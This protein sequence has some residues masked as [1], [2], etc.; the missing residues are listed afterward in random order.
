MV[1]NERSRRW[2]GLFSLG[3]VLIFYR[4]N[5]LRTFAVELKE[6]TKRVESV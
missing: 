5:I 6:E 3:E 2:V 1:R 4:Q